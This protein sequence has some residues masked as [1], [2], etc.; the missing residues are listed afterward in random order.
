MKCAVIQKWNRREKR[1]WPLKWLARLIPDLCIVCR[2]CVDH[3]K[4]QRSHNM[5]C[6]IWPLFSWSKCYSVFLVRAAHPIFRSFI[7]A[8]VRRPYSHDH[9]VPTL[10]CRQTF[11]TPSISGHFRF[12]HQRTLAMT[13]SM[14]WTWLCK[15]VTT[16]SQHV[17]W[18]DCVKADDCLT[19][20]TNSYT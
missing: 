14:L 15:L 19:T 10:S 12:R 3:L 1:V 2:D 18:L 9:R 7:T 13:A 17:T 5:P 16:G 8:T 6:F 11:G 4:G 20:A